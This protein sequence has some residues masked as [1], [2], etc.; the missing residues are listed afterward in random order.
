MTA[1]RSSLDNNSRNVL[2]SP[3]S[4]SA[5]ADKI[6]FRE[7]LEREEYDMGPLLQEDSASLRAFETDGAAR[8]I[9]KEERDK[10]I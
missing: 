3:S 7:Y 5:S 8:S 2:W 9:I 4:R 1:D 10:I 6:S